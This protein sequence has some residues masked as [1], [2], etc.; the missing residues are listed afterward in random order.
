MLLCSIIHYYIILHVIIHYSI[1]LDQM[2]CANHLC[3]EPARTWTI[4]VAATTCYIMLKTR[5]LFRYQAVAAVLVLA[6][7][8]NLYLLSALCLQTGVYFCPTSHLPPFLVPYC[9]LTCQPLPWLAI[10]C[11]KT[12][13]FLGCSDPSLAIELMRYDTNITATSFGTTTL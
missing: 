3:H 8:L 9:L 13:Y 1:C 6:V 5:T 10:G 7:H 12:L 2:Y 4:G 11:Y